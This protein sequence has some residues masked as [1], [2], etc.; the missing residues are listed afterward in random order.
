MSKIDFSKYLKSTDEYSQIK[1]TEF[2]SNLTNQPY[3]YNSVIGYKELI[4]NL[5][6]D[7]QIDFC[8]LEFQAHFEFVASEIFQIDMEKVKRE[9]KGTDKTANAILTA[10]EITPK[11]AENP[12][13]TLVWYK[14]YFNAILKKIL[15]TNK[16]ELGISFSNNINSPIIGAIIHKPALLKITSS[17]LIDSYESIFLEELGITSEQY[18]QIFEFPFALLFDVEIFPENKKPPIK[19]PF[20]MS[21]GRDI[22]FMFDS[23]TKH[24]FTNQLKKEF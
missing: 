4:E 18:K 9:L 23:V 22:Y 5:I 1:L 19:K 14:V 20:L 13:R 7:S 6:D 8:L 16:I 24:R 2:L 11:L 15:E 21:L 10:L 17:D 3:F 12:T